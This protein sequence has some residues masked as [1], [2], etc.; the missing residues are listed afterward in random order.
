MTGLPIASDLVA[1]IPF[2]E[3][4]P[5]IHRWWWLLIVPLAIGVSMTWKAVRVA[6][7]SRYW[8]DVAIMAFE[9][10]LAVGGIAV[11]LAI[12]IQWILPHLPAE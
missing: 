11:G 7:L 5:A 12:L 10:V 6:D 1:W 8:R 2:I 4:M 3:P 9:I